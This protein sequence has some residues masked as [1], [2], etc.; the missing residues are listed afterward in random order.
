M[1]QRRAGCT[2][3]LQPSFETLI[4]Q[5]D[6]GK[7]NNNK[8]ACLTTQRVAQHD[9]KA[10]D[11]I[12]SVQQFKQANILLFIEN[13]D[14]NILLFIG[15]SDNLKYLG[16]LASSELESDV[17]VQKNHQ[18]HNSNISWHDKTVFPTSREHVMTWTTLVSSS[19]V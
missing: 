19:I 15:Y 7:G 13:V 3:L 1:R 18:T 11:D 14:A 10:D 12:N 4:H 6:S 17:S 16:S 8:T 2:R 5:R 9:G